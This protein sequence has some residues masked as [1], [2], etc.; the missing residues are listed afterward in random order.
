MQTSNYILIYDEG[1]PMCVAYTS[2]FVN[3][4]F[5]KPEER[6]SFTQA[7]GHWLNLSNFERSRNEIPFL[8]TQ[9]GETLYGID[10]L[11]EILNRKIPFIKTI[12]NVAPVKYLLL[13]LYKL[14]S[15]NRKV[16]TG[17]KTKFNCVDCT[18]DFN[19]FYRI[20]FMLLSL[21]FITS[22]LSP[23]YRAVFS[24][25]PFYQLSILQLQT[26]HF[27]IVA[28]NI[29]IAYLLKGKKGVEYLGQ[30][31]MLALSA[32]LLT[33]PLLLANQLINFSYQWD[34]V[35]LSLIS[36]LMVFD[37]F[38]RIDFADLKQNGTIVT[39]NL[40]TFI[41]LIFFLL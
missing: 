34:V 21:V 23:L 12:G 31:N 39:V 36:T 16:I 24:K 14:I 9:T 3:T 40:L 26:V 15:F 1:C 30:M 41:T 27:S 13:R 10:A 19:L 37:Y 7:G 22:M 5:L 8:N 6:K 20:S 18:P 38:R 2:L 35:Y 28:T 29:F 25:F 33:I 17:N 4:G 32:I 11:L